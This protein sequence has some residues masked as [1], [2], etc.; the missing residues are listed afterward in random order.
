MYDV[1]KY[2]CMYACMYEFPDDNKQVIL[3]P[4]LFNIFCSCTF[5][6]PSNAPS[7]FAVEVLESRNLSRIIFM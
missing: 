4:K 3:E 6:W 1:C 5:K 2:V 7:P